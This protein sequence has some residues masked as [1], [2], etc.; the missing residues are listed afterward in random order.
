MVADA[1][2]N[3]TDGLA[4]GVTFA[5]G[6]GIPTAVAV[7]V[8]E[9]PH[10]LADFALL[11][12]NGL[13]KRTALLAQFGTSVGAIVGCLLGLSIPSG[14]RMHAFVGGGFIYVAAASALPTL[15]SGP[16]SKR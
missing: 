9:V 3:V 7:F 5:Q 10:N 4:L 6:S 1:M 14:P 8:H 16:D 2:H 13:S 11:L 15:L 12:Q